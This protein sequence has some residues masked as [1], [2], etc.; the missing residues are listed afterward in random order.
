[1]GPVGLIALAWLSMMHRAW[2][3][4]EAGQPLPSLRFETLKRHPECVTQAIFERCGLPAGDVERALG[5]LQTDSQRG[6]VV[7]RERTSKFELS[8]RDRL[9]IRDVLSRHPV[10]DRPDFELPAPLVSR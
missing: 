1:M 3:M 9:T 5:A 10:I 7:G 8:A 2:Q 4:A 6:S